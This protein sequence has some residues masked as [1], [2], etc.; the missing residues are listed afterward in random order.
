MRFQTGR[1][2]W[3]ETCQVPDSEF[4]S[5]R[6]LLA[7]ALAERKLE[8]LIVSFTT[9]VRYLT[10]F[11]GSN[12]ILLVLPA[13]ALFLT[14]PRYRLQSAREVD[15]RRR[16]ASGPLLPKL[17]SAVEKMKLRRLGFEKSRMS[18][19]G[20]EFLKSRLPMRTSLEPVPG[21]VEELRMR[22]SEREIALVR[23]SVAANSEA[24]EQAVSQ[25]RVGMREVDLAAELD[26][27]MRRLGAERTAFET[28][29]AA[30]PRSALPHAQPTAAVLKA[31]DLVLVDMGAIREGYASDMTRMLILGRA[32]AK[33]KQVYRAVLEAQLAAIAAVRAG[34]TAKH[35][36]GEARRVLKSEKLDRAF[37]HSTG[38]G[39]G[40]EIHEPPRIGKKEKTRLQKGMAI[41][42]E[43]GVYLEGFGGIRIEDTVV[44]TENGCEV[45]TPTSKEL[46]EI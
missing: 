20:Y 37:V 4:Q 14:D 12:G 24:F 5:R 36:D 33:V 18:Y 27:R 29:I 21:L 23:D 35:V 46:R 30:G 2:C 42:I 22:K 9:N 16:V 43:P 34:V 41:T 26:Y 3:P 19:E 38:H 28:I 8:A 15:C 13:G 40:L 45:L 6:Q 11:T 39:L 7:A 25:M 44:V 1:S 31:N 17:V 32:S 10:G